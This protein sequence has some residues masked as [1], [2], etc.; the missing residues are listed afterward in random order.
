MKKNTIL[1]VFH[2]NE[3][4]IP[5]STLKT[6]WSEPILLANPKLSYVELTNQKLESDR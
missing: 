3:T 5:T 6:K 4:L 1:H 2:N